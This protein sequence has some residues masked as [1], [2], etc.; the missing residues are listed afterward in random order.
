[1][2]GVKHAWI[3]SQERGYDAPDKHV[4][5]DCVED[6]FLKDL[7]SNSVVEPTCD[8][9][10]K[11]SDDPIAAPVD[12]IMPSIAYALHSNFAP[13]ES[14]GVPRDDGDWVDGG[15]ITDTADALESF[16]LSCHDDLR[17]EIADAFHNDAWYPCTGGHWLDTSLHD[18]LRYSWEHFVAVVKHQSRFFFSVGDKKKREREDSLA[19]I[20]ILRRISELVQTLG[21]IYEIAPKTELFRVRRT[22]PDEMFSTLSELGPP[23]EEV[24]TAGRMNPAG[25]SYF[26]VAL[27][28]KTACAE[29]LDRPPTHGA[30]ASFAVQQKLIVLD[31]ARVPDVP[32]IYDE[33][34]AHEREIILFL[35]GF[36]NAITKSTLKDGREHVEYVP[37]QVV[38]EFF[39]QVFRTKDKQSLDGIV[40]PSAVMPGGRNLVIFPPRDYKRPLDKLVA[41]TRVFPLHVSDWPA[42]N[43]IL[44][45]E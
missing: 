25:I 1:M 18:H 4:C 5:A 10:D 29:V 27:E 38:S 2:G 33:R 40:Y 9:C 44:E 35:K 30:L 37:S 39:A 3:E 14:A 36:I 13:P 21:L 45:R 26:Y 23:P 15:R 11:T 42:M 19:P 16:P 22:N 20:D 7:I 31:L 32:S 12:A 24:A 28:K 8:Y 34:V 6:P 41:L 17:Q 43:R